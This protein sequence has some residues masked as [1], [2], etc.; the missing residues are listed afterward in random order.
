MVLQSNL[1]NLN[2]FSSK[3]SITRT[4]S[5]SLEF[6]IIV[7]LLDNLNFLTDPFKFG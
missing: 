3:S 2:F 1:V 6:A 5:R 7:L 4:F